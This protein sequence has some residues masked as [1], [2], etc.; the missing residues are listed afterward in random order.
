[1]YTPMPSAGPLEAF[2]REQR[3]KTQ[4]PNS[5]MA[6]KAISKGTG[7]LRAACQV[8]FKQSIPTIKEGVGPQLAMN[9]KIGACRKP[10]LQP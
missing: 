5:V 4:T 9:R 8:D 1:M 7:T 10:M 6:E 3:T 2:G